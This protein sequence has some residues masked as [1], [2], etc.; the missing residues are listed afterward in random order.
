VAAKIFSVTAIICKRIYRKLRLSAKGSGRYLQV[1][2]GY[3]KKFVYKTSDI[4][5]FE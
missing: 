1:Q 2:E 4:V 5:K 3:Y